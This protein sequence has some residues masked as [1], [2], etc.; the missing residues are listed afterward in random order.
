MPFQIIR[1]RHARNFSL[2]FRIFSPDRYNDG[3]AQDTLT[4]VRAFQSGDSH[5]QQALFQHYLP[6][7]YAIAR[8]KLGPKLREK[9]QSGDIVQEVFTRILKGLDSFEPRSEASFSH[10]VSRLVANEIAD[11]R[12]FFSAKKR[13]Q[14]QES[15]L[16]SDTEYF[17]PVDPGPSPH[18]WCELRQE[19]LVLEKCL[20]RLSQ[21]N[22][23]IILMRDIA[24]M[25][26]EEIG[27]E[28]HISSDGARMA[29]G[30]AKAKLAEAVR[31]LQKD[32]L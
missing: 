15:H 28:T 11:Q 8:A 31:L 5:A 32:P 19:H 16:D 30:R 24:Q 14:A 27:G 29:Y 1:Y 22:R 4:L 13:A 26:F 23:D 21:K 9:L 20:D 12:D 10:W 6:K 3:M 17:E 2:S 18:A 25:S 7:V